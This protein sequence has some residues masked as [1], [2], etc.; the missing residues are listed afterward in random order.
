MLRRSFLALGLTAITVIV[1]ASSRAA[2]PLKDFTLEAPADGSKFVLSEHRGGYVA[3]HFLLKTEC[4]YCQRMTQAYAKLAAEQPEMTHV[5][6]KPDAAEEILRWTKGLDP[7][8]LAE[9]P[10]IYRDPDAQLAKALKIP[11]G[12]KFHGETV[13][14]PTVILVDPQGKELFRYVGKSNADRLSPADFVKRW[15]THRAATK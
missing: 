2:E 9:L 1:A 8:G 13:R 10:K 15:E 4:P 11:G 3:L 6:I 14:Y 12:Y 7:A 5:F